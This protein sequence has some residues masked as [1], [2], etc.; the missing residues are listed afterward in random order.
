MPHPKPTDFKMTKHS[1]YFVER[2]RQGAWLD[3]VTTPLIRSECIL[4]YKNTSLWRELSNQKY[5]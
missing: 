2:T 4:V 3:T 5:C 1:D